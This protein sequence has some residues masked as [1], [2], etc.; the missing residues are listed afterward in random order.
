MYVHHPLWYEKQTYAEVLMMCLF[1]LLIV[2]K[3]HNLRLGPFTDENYKAN[4]QL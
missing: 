1:V 4:L 2:K 3:L